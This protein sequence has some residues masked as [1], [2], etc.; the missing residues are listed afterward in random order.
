[1]PYTLLRPLNGFEVRQRTKDNFVAINDLLAAG[2]AARISNHLP[3]K[4]LPDYFNTAEAQEF[5]EALKVAEGISTVKSASRG[6]GGVTW[7]HPLLALD[8]ALWLSP[9]LKVEVYKWIADQL[10]QRR[11]DSGESFKAMNAELDAKYNIG[12]KHWYYTNTANLIKEKVGADSWETATEA[13]LVER[14]RL[15]K[16]VILLCKT[17]K[18]MPF[19][20]L[21]HMAVEN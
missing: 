3:I 5:I 14:D 2:N 10:L 11:V 4:R 7:A 1:M 19:D 8:F 18:V 21:I 16:N 13:Q 17:S 12:A 6:R 15:Q 9:S 20:N